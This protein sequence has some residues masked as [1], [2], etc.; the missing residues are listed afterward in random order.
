MEMLDW[1]YPMGDNCEIV[2][3]YEYVY[4]VAEIRHAF[5]FRNF[6]NTF[7][8]CYISNN[9]TIRCMVEMVQW[10]IQTS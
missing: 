9:F 4:G 3:L 1:V 5:S 7:H 8:I 6:T 2:E 10:V